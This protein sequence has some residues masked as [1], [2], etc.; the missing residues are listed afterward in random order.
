MKYRCNHI[1]YPYHNT[2]LNSLS[3]VIM[4]GSAK[5]L[6]KAELNQEIYCCNKEVSIYPH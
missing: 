3:F 4:N 5:Y 6:R 2:T 1:M